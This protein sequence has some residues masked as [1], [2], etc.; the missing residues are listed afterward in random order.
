M[1][2]VGERGRIRNLAV[3][4]GR[5]GGVAVADLRHIQS[6]GML[7]V[8]IGIGDDVGDRRYMGVVGNATGI[9]GLF[10]HVEGVGSGF[11]ERELRE[12]K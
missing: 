10:R 3:G 6:A 4:F 12:L 2:R 5:G 11:S 9:A 7:A 1:I 8:G